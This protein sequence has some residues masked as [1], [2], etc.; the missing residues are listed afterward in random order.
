MLHRVEQWHSDRLGVGWNG[1]GAKD[2]DSDA[3]GTQETETRVH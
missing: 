1:V 3:K 2:N